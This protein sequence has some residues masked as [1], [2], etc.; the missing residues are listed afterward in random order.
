MNRGGE[1]DSIA[2][3]DGGACRGAS[4]ARGTA[5]SVMGERYGG[6]LAGRAEVWRWCKL[7]K[8]FRSGACSP[9]LA[10]A[11]TVIVPT[12]LPHLTKLHQRLRTPLKILHRVCAPAG[13]RPLSDANKSPASASYSPP[14]PTRSANPAAIVTMKLTFK[15][16][17][18]HQPR[19]TAC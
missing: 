6:S 4:S 1:G 13:P 18:A 5:A 10:V 17:V 12:S 14:H 15:V 7:A 19:P 16:C 3:A 8:T 9:P 2:R 11:R